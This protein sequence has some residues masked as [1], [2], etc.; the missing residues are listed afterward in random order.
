MTK[1]RHLFAIIT[2]GFLFPIGASNAEVLC[3]QERPLKPVKCVCGKL[4]DQSG[5][6][7]SGAKIQP[8]T[9]PSPLVNCS[10]ELRAHAESFEPFQSPSVVA[11]PK[12]KCRHKLVI[13]LMLPYPDNCGSYVMKQ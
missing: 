6:P 8:E 3:D 5:A 4:I 12:K 7:V 11:N 2:V 10:Y 1:K 9:A 13:L